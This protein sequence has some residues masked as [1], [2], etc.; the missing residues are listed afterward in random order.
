MHSPPPSSF[1][2]DSPRVGVVGAGAA[3]AL[4]ARMLTDRGLSVVVFDKGRGAGG[5]MSTRR[6]DAA[7]FD[8]G[9][10]FFTA[11]DPQLAPRIE[12]WERA[13]IVQ[14]WEGPFVRIESGRVVPETP[15]EPRWVAKPGMNALVKHLLSG[16]DVRFG[17]R[18]M[19]VRRRGQTWQVELD[20]ESSAVFDLVV[21]AIPAPQAV[22]LLTEVPSLRESMG[23]VR[24]APC[25]AAMFNG[26]G[27]P[28][29]S[30]AAAKVDDP[31]I[32][33]IARNETKPDRPSAPQWVVHAS[34]QWSRAHLEDSAATVKVALAAETARIIGEDHLAGDGWAHRWRYA[35][36][37][38]PVGVP[39]L[40]ESE[41][42]VCGDGL[43]GGRVESALLSGA[44]L[45]QRV[46]AMA[47]PTPAS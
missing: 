38:T 8:H 41:V 37:E 40:L 14:R 30:W 12:Q 20:N 46:L 7:R 16:L 28:G 5:R 31:T 27:R 25:W 9:A 42:G 34:P 11:R 13:G 17:Q 39:C 32:S 35:L 2:V 44:A 10:Q 1:S 26:T 19:A 47:R 45:A 23:A 22:A 6:I 43:L 36:V 24:A 3:G 21:I 18:A 15:V 4:C 33:W 29:P